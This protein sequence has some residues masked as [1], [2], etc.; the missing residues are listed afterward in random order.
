MWITVEVERVLRVD[1]GRNIILCDPMLGP[2]DQTLVLKL[3]ETE[4]TDKS[5][6]RDE[7]PTGLPSN[8]RELLAAAPEQRALIPKGPKEAVGNPIAWM[9]R[10]HIEA[11]AG[12]RKDGIA[13]A[14]YA[15]S[16]FF[17]VPVYSAV[18]QQSA[19]EPQRLRSALESIAD[20]RNVNISGEY[21]Q[22][23]RDII[24]SIVDCAVAALDAPM[25]SR[26]APQA[27]PMQAKPRPADCVDPM[28]CL[29]RHVP[30]VPEVGLHL[31]SR[32]GCHHTTSAASQVSRPQH[33]TGE[34]K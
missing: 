19:D 31:C 1:R 26:P 18:P 6:S 5:T 9:N 8:W 21:E 24:R 32:F 23:L 4:M 28:G 25:L 3:K 12:G 13:W 30:T 17:S 34:E 10:E 2:Q 29:W 15:Q 7:I 14:S 11:Y 33:S 16:K 27:V 20:W 22:G